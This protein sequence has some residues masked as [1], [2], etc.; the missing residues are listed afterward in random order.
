MARGVRKIKSKL[1]G[2]IELFC[3][4][5][6]SY[7]KGKSEIYTL[8]SSRL[9]KHYFNILKDIERVQLGYDLI[10]NIN[11]VTEAQPGPEYFRLLEESFSALNNPEIDKELIK[12]WFDSQIIKFSGHEPNLVYDSENKKLNEDDNFVFDTTNMCFKKTS[13]G[14]YSVKDIKVLRLFFG[15]YD[16]NKLSNVSDLTSHIGNI[17]PLIKSIRASYL[18]Y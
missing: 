16:I 10:K 1:A 14:R 5:D 18:N 9:D 11:K 15:N 4:N 2:G 6:I 12:Y 17:K 3:I 13:Q 8:T 7:I